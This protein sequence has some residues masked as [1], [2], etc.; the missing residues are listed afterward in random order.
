MKF[1]KKQH[2]HG[3]NG[4]T[5]NNAD[6]MKLLVG[7][8]IPA[9]IVANAIRKNG[10]HPLKVA[11]YIFNRVETGNLPESGLKYHIQSATYKSYESIMSTALSVAN[12]K[13]K[14]GYEIIDIQIDSYQSLQ[15]HLTNTLLSDDSKERGFFASFVNYMT[16][17]ETT[18]SIILYRKASSLSQQRVS[19]LYIASTVRYH[20]PLAESLLSALP[21]YMDDSANV[22]SFNFDTFKRQKI[23]YTY[24]CL[25]YYSE[26][27]SS[28]NAVNSLTTIRMTDLTTYLKN[29]FSLETTLNVVA[30]TNIHHNKKRSKFQCLTMTYKYETYETIVK[31]LISQATQ[32][33]RKIISI[34]LDTFTPQRGYFDFAHQWSITVGIIIYD[35]SIALKSTIHYD[36]ETARF[37]YHSSMYHNMDPHFVDISESNRLLLNFDSFKP[38]FSISNRNDVTYATVFRIQ[39][40]DEP[41]SD[42]APEEKA[43]T[44]PRKEKQGK[45]RKAKKGDSS[46]TSLKND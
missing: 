21:R 13:V 18:T 36:I 9:A 19:A 6:S 11:N 34:Q 14:Q 33:S 28:L 12:K 10:F 3:G 38:L 40:E 4:K 1:S 29:S 46:S 44:T 32:L 30:K 45:T 15:T 8:G 7:I 43:M 35:D 16:S 20:F 25:F 39:E 17:L 22:I 5:L 31:D 42:K 2:F 37:L 41:P 26:K 24:F 27:D 23:E